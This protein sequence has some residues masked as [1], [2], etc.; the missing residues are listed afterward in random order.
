VLRPNP[1]IDFFIIALH[2]GNHATDEPGDT[3]TEKRTDDKN[4]NAKEELAD[5]V[6]R[7]LCTNYSFFETLETLCG[8]NFRSTRARTGAA[9]TAQKNAFS[10]G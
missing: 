7:T 4:C 5:H 9:P 8:S 10:S 6:I 2:V 1:A 3:A